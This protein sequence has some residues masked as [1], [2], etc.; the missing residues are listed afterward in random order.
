[1]RKIVDAGALISIRADLTFGSP[2]SKISER[3]SEVMQRLAREVNGFDISVIRIP[4]R[5]Q[6]L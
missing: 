1:M 3:I 4:V 2:E 6:E 5:I